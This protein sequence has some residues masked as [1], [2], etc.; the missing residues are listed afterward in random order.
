MVTGAPGMVLTRGEVII[1][2]GE[3]KGRR[4]RGEFVKR[5]PGPPLV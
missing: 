3:F 1:D 2:H 5:A 4:G